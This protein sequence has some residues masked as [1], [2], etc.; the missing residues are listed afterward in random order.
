MAKVYHSI[1]LDEEHVGLGREK[2]TRTAPGEDRTR[3]SFRE[4][5]AKHGVWLG[6]AVLL[7]ISM[8]LFTISMCMRDAR[9]SDLTY[10][11]KYST[12]CALILVPPSTSPI[13]VPRH[14]THC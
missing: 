12:Y 1:P 14:A 5:L 13:F 7:S 4:K 9:P 10:T 6:H 11:Q 3:T 2:M 8:T